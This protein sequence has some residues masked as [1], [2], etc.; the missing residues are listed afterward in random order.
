MAV[1]VRGQ[2]VRGIGASPDAVRQVTEP[3]PCGGLQPVAAVLAAT[4]AA[5]FASSARDL[6][7]RTRRTGPAHAATEKAHDD[8]AALRAKLHR[9]IGELGYAVTQSQPC[10]QRRPLLINRPSCAAE[11]GPVSDCGA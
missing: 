10:V 8:L 2:G 7:R 9:L 3:W 6:A 4:P 11:A 1:S 5:A